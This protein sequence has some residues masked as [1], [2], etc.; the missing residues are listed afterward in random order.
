MLKAGQK[1]LFKTPEPTASFK[2]GSLKQLQKNFRISYDGNADNVSHHMKVLDES[3]RLPRK[4][5]ETP[6][7]VQPLK[8]LKGKPTQ[9]FREGS[10]N[11]VMQ[12]DSFN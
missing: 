11:Y 7:S 6:M 12:E 8:T 1:N 2:P 5:Y 9:P 3:N 10:N 4:S